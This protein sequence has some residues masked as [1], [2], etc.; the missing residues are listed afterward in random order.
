MLKK[1]YIYYSDK[2]VEEKSCIC[3]SDANGV[4]TFEINDS[5]L[6]ENVDFIEVPI[7]DEPFYFGDDGFFLIQSKDFGIGYFTEKESCA[8]I[9]PARMSFFGVKHGQDCIVPI[10]TGF[11]TDLYQSFKVEDNQYHLNMR[12]N[13]CNRKPFENIKINFHTFKNKNATYV[14]FAKIYR[15]FQLANGFCSLKERNNQYISYMSE[16]ANI[17]IRMGWKPV[18]VEIFEQT[19]ET[20]PD[21]H[22]ACTFKDVEDLMDEFYKSGIKKAEFCLVGWNVKGHDGRWPQI[23]PVEESLGGEKEL[24]KLLNKAKKYNYLVTCHTN[25]TDAYSIAE[26]FRLGDIAQQYDGNLSVEACHWAGGRTY[27]ICPE[28]AY[29]ISI[30]TLPEVA[31]L[32]FRGMH[33]ID[34]ITCTPARECNSPAHPVNKREGCEYFNKL[35]A[36]SKKMFGAVGSEGPYDQSLKECDSALYISFFDYLD[37]EKTDLSPMFDES[38]PLWQIVYHGIVFSNPYTRTVN[39]MNTNEKDDLLKCIEYGG[40]PQIYYYASFVNKKDG[41]WIGREDLYC[42]TD[43]ERKHS[44][45]IVKDTEETFKEL[46]YLQ[47]EFIDN[48]K[49]ISDHI[50][51]TTYSDGSVVTVDYNKKTYSLKKN[52]NL[53]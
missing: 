1:Y 44:V 7:T 6:Y 18:P 25:S 22:I 9:S 4:Y 52:D 16:S 30:K 37:K 21:M 26:N 17:R 8:D 31:K 43:E 53:K 35:F 19:I 27:N 5:I 34:V 14:D 29:E 23:L 13:I 49:K 39:V 12:F 36:E 42:H 11:Y 46:N 10:I 40:R 3:K 47:Y 41:N 32:G 24:K 28:K 51:E 38:I 15:S 50:Y 20:E 48:H 45:K 33:Y 2:S